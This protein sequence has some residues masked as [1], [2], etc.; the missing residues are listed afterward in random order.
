MKYK[1]LVSPGITNLGGRIKFSLDYYEQ[2]SKKKI[3]DIRRD[4]IVASYR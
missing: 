1:M 4:M 3:F 2:N